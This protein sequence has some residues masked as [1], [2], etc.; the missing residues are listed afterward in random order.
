MVTLPP[1]QDEKGGEQFGRCLW[2][3]Y[4]ALT[5]LMQFATRM[6][7]FQADALMTTGSWSQSKPQENNI[8][9]H[10]LT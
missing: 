6:N 8:T 3:F 10:T 9:R 5:K 2:P 1:G 4:I 7:R